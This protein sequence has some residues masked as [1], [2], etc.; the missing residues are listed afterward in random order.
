MSLPRLFTCLM[1]GSDSA[2]LLEMHLN[3]TSLL[4]SAWVVVEAEVSL[5]GRKR[6]VN[7][8]MISRLAVQYGVDRVQ[9]VIVPAAEMH[10][11]V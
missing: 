6:S 4:V 5:A 1:V 8:A 11:A 3:A 7:H 10:I 2:S 9:H